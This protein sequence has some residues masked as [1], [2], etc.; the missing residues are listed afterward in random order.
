MKSPLLEFD[1]KIIESDKNFASLKITNNYL[2][3]P[4]LAITIGNSLRRILLNG[5]MGTSIVQVC[6]NKPENDSLFLEA[7]RE[8]FFEIINNIKKIKLRASKL[9]SCDVKIVARG[10]AVITAGDLIASKNIMVVN[11]NQYLF[12]IV[13]NTTLDLSLKVEQGFGYKFY[14]ENYN[15]FGENPASKL[16]DANFSPVTKVNYKVLLEE[17]NIFRNKLI[18]S[19]ILEI[20]TDGSIAPI[21]AFLEANKI[22]SSIFISFIR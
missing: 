21:R 7:V 1:Y 6:V 2:T 20:W 15:N 17:S 14:N 4:G 5:L 22:L 3:I 18:E 9:E 10:P 12:T 11:P 16:I 19:L 13:N 8:D